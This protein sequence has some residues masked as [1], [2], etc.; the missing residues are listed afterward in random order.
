M[1][2]KYVKV[3]GVQWCPVHS[4]LYDEIN[5]GDGV[6]CDNNSD[7]GAEGRCVQRTLYVKVKVK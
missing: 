5:D 3:D 2:Y 1:T 4:G 6:H 7:K